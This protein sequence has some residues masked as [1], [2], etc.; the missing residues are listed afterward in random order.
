MAS[1][2]LRTRSIGSPRASRQPRRPRREADPS[3]WLASTTRRVTVSFAERTTYV[4]VGPSRFI[5]VE[6][7]RDARPAYR[8]F[9]H[10]RK[11]PRRGRGR[12]HGDVSLNPTG[13]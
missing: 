6:Q 2:P 13:I 7:R 5:H 9:G 3:W 8:S 12:D 1:R 11:E 4:P 10:A